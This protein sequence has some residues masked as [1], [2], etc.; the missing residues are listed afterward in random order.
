MRLEDEFA[1]AAPIQEV[2]ATIL[3]VERVTG[4][5]PG[6]ELLGNDGDV[7]NVG[8]RVKV[9]PISMQYRGDVEIVER[10]EAAHTAKMRV[11]GREVRGQGTVEA[12]A[13]LRLSE[14]GST[15]R[16]AIEVEVALSGRA[17]SMGQGAIQDVSSKL[18]GRF[19]RNLARMLEADGAAAAG[20]AGAAGA[21]AGEPLS[22]DPAAAAAQVEREVRDED[23]N[24]ISG[25]EIVGAVVRGRLSSPLVSAGL[26][27]V[28]LGLLGFLLG[29]R[30]G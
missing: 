27:G 9:G 4:C 5:V 1:V 2:Y 29:R 8:I 13:Q 15:T 28:T 19:A 18:V 12:T 25:R 11:K 7:H 23:E 30:A 22:S 26:A 21:P 6:A 16:G 14:D 20:A 17:A 10:D 3:D 24:A